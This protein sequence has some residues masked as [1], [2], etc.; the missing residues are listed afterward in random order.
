M[1]SV[2]GLRRALHT[3]SCA[4][5]HVIAVAGD[6]CKGSNL[7]L[8]RKLFPARSNDVA[9]EVSHYGERSRPTKPH[10]FCQEVAKPA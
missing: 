5:V 1:I 10:H 2:A 8:I 7:C 3:P 6:Q 9:E 4:N